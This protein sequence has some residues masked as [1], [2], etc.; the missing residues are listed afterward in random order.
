MSYL[1]DKLVSDEQ[2]KNN[3]YFIEGMGWYIA[4]PMSPSWSFKR[5]KSRL[6]NTWL[7]LTGRA[8]AVHFKE[9]EK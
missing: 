4:K 7:V 1:I 2:L 5:L 3:Q 6:K 9:D 8:I